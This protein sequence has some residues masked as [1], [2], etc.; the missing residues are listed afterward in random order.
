MISGFEHFYPTI[1]QGRIRFSW[2]GGAPFYP[3]SVCETL[4]AEDGRFVKRR[5]VVESYEVRKS[6]L[7]KQLYPASFIS[8]RILFT[9]TRQDGNFVL[10]ASAFAG[11]AKDRDRGEGRFWMRL[12]EKESQELKQKLVEVLVAIK[13]GVEEAAQRPGA[14]ALPAF[15]AN[16]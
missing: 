12:G 2:I 10:G 6:L 13:E 4:S 9:V 14:C 16:G 15:S 8:R 11:P 1:F 7:L 3:G 5:F